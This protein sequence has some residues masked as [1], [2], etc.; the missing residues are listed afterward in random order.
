MG[1]KGRRPRGQRGALLSQPY[2]CYPVV[3]A[4]AAAVATTS[5]I[6]GMPLPDCQLPLL[7]QWLGCQP[8]SQPSWGKRCS[9][10]RLA[11]H[12]PASQPA[13]QR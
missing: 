3:A 4:T 12:M 2:S 5:T 13:S 1:S 9:R 6:A 11:G 10:Q 8:A 7:V